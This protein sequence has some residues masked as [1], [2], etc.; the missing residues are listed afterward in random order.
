[1][2]NIYWTDSQV[3]LGCLKNYI[4]R[5]K[6]FVANREQLIRD[7]SNIYQWY[8]VDT[9]ENPGDFVSGGLDVNQKSKVGKWFQGAAFLW[10][11][12]DTWNV[13]ETTPELSV[14][15][16]EVKKQVVVNAVHTNLNREFLSIIL[17]TTADCNRLKRIMAS[18]IK[19]G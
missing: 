14:N 7:H 4:K 9:A 5:F 12:K 19:Q 3:V 16:P 17:K 15:G 8:Y 18:V 13:I 2:G 11:N 10:Q 6:V 1:M